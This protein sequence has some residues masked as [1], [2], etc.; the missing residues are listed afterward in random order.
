MADKLHH[1]TGCRQ[2]R[3]CKHLIST[4][5]DG[6]FIYN[7]EFP[8]SIGAFTTILKAPH[9]KT[10]DHTTSKFLDIVHL[11]IAF[12]DCMSVGGFK[13]ALNFVD[14]AT[15]FNWCFGLKSLHHYNI[16][17]AVLAFHSKAGS[18]ACQFK[19]DCD[20]KFFGRHLCLFLH[21][22]R[23]SIAS[24]PAGRQSA[25][26]L[27]E[28]HWNFLVHMSRAYL[29]EK[30]MPRSFWYYAIKHSAQMMNMIPGHYGGKLASPF[31]FVHGVRR[32]QRT[33]LPLFS[34]CYFHHEKR[35]NV[36]RSKNQ[37]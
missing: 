1:I 5:K 30:Q 6:S 25:N 13:Y 8:M 35:S 27:V 23:S 7:G 10:I 17:T 11:D 28:S 2:F 29:T 16:I 32:D 24:S 22:N 3:S 18:L 9:G 21:L 4:M 19:Y 36:Q 31:M 14:R 26:G 34:I 33:W 15:H 20:E 37:T 12:D